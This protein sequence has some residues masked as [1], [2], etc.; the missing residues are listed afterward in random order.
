MKKMLLIGVISAALLVGGATTVL[1]AADNESLS[2]I[3]S[4][5]SEM[6]SIQKQI[7][8][9][10][11]D[12][13]TITQEQADTI[14]EAIDQREEYNNQAVDNGQVYGPGYGPGYGMGMGRGFCGGPGGY[15]NGSVPNGSA[16]NTSLN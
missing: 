11:V 12:A 5:Y 7:V 16:S 15:Y 10:Q 13:G 4:L 3:K 1:G 14:K 8:D 9:K 6:F 2:E